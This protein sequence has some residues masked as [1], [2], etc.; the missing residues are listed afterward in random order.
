M[1]LYALLAGLIVAAHL[2]FAIFAAAGGFL[3]LR[4]RRLAWVHVPAV[5]WA[6]YIEVTG[7]I[8]P[9]TPLENQWRQ[10]AG[11]DRY[12]G[13]FIAQYVFPALYPEGLTVE[14]Q[15]AIAVLVLVVN[16]GIYGWLL[17]RSHPSGTHEHTSNVSTR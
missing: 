1:N 12:S 16:V 10:R 7:G 15:F 6:V 3:V 13:D 17:L 8:C 11:L 5:A 9:L 2:A 4:W 14:A